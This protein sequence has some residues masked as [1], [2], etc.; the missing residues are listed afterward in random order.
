MELC[1]SSRHALRVNRTSA[2]RRVEPRFAVSEPV[3]VIV[4]DA[5]RTFSGRTLEASESGLSIAN[6]LPLPL[7]TPLKLG[8]ADAVVLGE[9][10]I[11][12]SCRLIPSSVPRAS[13]SST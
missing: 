12:T 7:G 1:L 6:P 2:E 8:V 9:C 4:L 13:S 10:A 5:Y 11:A 3:E